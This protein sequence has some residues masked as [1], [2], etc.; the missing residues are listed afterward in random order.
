MLH[1]QPSIMELGKGDPCRWFTF[2]P[3]RN[4]KNPIAPNRSRKNFCYIE[5]HIFTVWSLTFYFILLIKNV[6]IYECFYA[7]YHTYYIKLLL[8]YFYPLL[9]VQKERRHSI[10]H[11]SIYSVTFVTLAYA[12]I[13]R[14]LHTEYILSWKVLLEKSRSWTIVQNEI[15]NF[16]PKFDIPW[17]KFGMI[18]HISNLTSLQF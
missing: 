12:S 5:I 17:Y 1:F 9:D 8:A 18:N 6:W 16:E 3:F 10:R 13:I 2:K 14:T 11:I 15:D 4:K 7:W